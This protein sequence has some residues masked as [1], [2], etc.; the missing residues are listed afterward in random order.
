VDQGALAQAR[1]KAAEAAAA[2]AM[3]AAAQ[4]AEQAAQQLSQLA[5]ATAQQMGMTPGGL[6]GQQGS[7]VQGMAGGRGLNQGGAGQVAPVNA[8][9]AA[10][11]ATFAGG[12]WLRSKGTLTGQVQDAGDDHTPVDYRDL[13]KRYF[14]AVS[15]EGTKQE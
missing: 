6:P 8:P 14:Q 4:A 13:V 10:L 15:Q 5:A 7:R 12:G 1:D 9:D 2:P 3:S 11:S